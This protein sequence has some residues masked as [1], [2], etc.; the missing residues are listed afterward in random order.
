VQLNRRLN[1]VIPV[2]RAD[3]SGDVYVHST[4]ISREAFER[5]FLIISKTFAWIYNQGL[6][7]LSGPRVALMLMR[8]VAESSVLADGPPDAREA[9]R[10]LA[11]AEVDSFV[12]EVRRLTNVARP[13]P[14]GWEVVPY[15]EAVD[16]GA[17]DADDRAEVDNLIVF[18]TVVSAV[19]RRDEVGTILGMMEQL[20]GAQTTSS[21]C[22]EFAASLGTSTATGST[23]ERATP[24]SIPS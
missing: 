20:W 7:S 15:Q 24:S 17:L 2:S 5:H 11:L 9:S 12:A 6:G 19:H 13:G 21:T 22:T 1:L 16:R 18:F 14:G 8:K 23:G 3:G 10:A 4:P